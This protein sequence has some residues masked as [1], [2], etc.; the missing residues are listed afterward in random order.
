MNTSKFAGKRFYALVSRMGGKFR[1]IH[2]LAIY[3]FRQNG[4]PFK[5]SEAMPCVANIGQYA[6]LRSLTENCGYVFGRPTLSRMQSLT[7][8][9]IDRLIGD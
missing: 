9:E 7:E 1:D 5:K 6:T 4:V 3:E 2:A 8:V